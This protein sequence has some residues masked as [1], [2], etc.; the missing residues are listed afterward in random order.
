MPYI[1]PK[2]SLLYQGI[3]VDQAV[4]LKNF[5]YFTKRTFQNQS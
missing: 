3:D 5:I 1:F 2:E 4:K